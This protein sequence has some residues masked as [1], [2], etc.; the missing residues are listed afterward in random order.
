M[1]KYRAL[2]FALGSISSLSFFANNQSLTGKFLTAASVGA[3]VNSSNLTLSYDDF[4]STVKHSITGALENTANFGIGYGAKKCIAPL[5][6]LITRSNFF[7]NNITNHMPSNIVSVIKNHSPLISFVLNA[8]A[9]IICTTI[10]AN[11]F[12]K[13]RTP[14]S[15]NSVKSISTDLKYSAFLL[16]IAAGYISAQNQR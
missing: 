8:P 7:R 11:Y 4:S 9:V 1:N 14:D 3:T 10:I 16:T 2:S 6:N 13:P 15:S 12:N 5:L